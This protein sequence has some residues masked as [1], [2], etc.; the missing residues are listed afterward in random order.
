MDKFVFQDTIIQAA[1]LRNEAN[2]GH[3]DYYI[4]TS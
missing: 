3:T 1:G 4:N 2:T